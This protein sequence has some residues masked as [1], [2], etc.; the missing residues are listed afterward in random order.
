MYVSGHLDVA[1]AVPPGIELPVPIAQEVGWA[2]RAGLK[3]VEK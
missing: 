1:V 2:L 3:T